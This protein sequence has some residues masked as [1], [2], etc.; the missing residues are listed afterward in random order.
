VKKQ[1]KGKAKPLIF[2]NQNLKLKATNEQQKLAVTGSSNQLQNHSNSDGYITTKN[3][4]KNVIQASI[5]LK[6]LVI[7][8]CFQLI[9][10]EALPCGVQ[11][12]ELIGV[13]LCMLISIAHNQ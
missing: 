6:Q 7:S 13:V 2:L 4:N 1:G 10:I 5:C 12:I 9:T 8:S 11:Q 3:T